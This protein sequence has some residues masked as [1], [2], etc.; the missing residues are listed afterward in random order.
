MSNFPEADKTGGYGRFPMQE[1]A[2]RPKLR[3][4]VGSLQVCNLKFINIEEFK[5]KLLLCA[6]LSAVKLV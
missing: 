4:L 3:K 1:L 5:Y 6:I 2:D